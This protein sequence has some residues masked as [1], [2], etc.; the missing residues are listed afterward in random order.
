MNANTHLWSHLAE[1][2]LEWEIQFQT[3]VVE[4]SKTHILCSN[5]YFENRAVYEITC[6]NNVQQEIPEITLTAHAHYMLYT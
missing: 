4:K 3:K 1:F 6:K 2:S 5:F